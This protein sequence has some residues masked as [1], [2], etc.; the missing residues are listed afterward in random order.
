M[1]YQLTEARIH[2][3]A[4][5]KNINNLK[6]LLSSNTKFMA[7]VKADAYGHG[8]TNIAL[9]AL[10]SGAHWLGVARFEEALHI[11]HNKICAPLLVF[12]YVHPKH[13]STIYDRDIIST[14]YDY[15]MAKAL[16]KAAC[17]DNITIRAHLKIDT[18]MGRVGIVFGPDQV[19]SK[20]RKTIVRE[21]KKIL[22]LPGLKIEGIYTHLAASDNKDTTYTHLQLDAFD[23]LL[24]TLKKENIKFK[25]CHAANS[26]GILAFPRSHYDM[27]RAG[28]S[29]YGLY[30]SPEIDRSKAVL[31]PAMTLKSIIT[32]VRKVPKGFKVSYG[33]THETKE[34]TMLASVPVGYADGFSRLFSS[35]GVMLVKGQRAPVVGRVCM[36]Q[37]V[38]DIGHIPNVKPGDQVIL[39][40]EQGKESI[41]ADELANLAGTIN[42]EIV[43][44]LTARVE[45]IIF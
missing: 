3:D 40:G 6:S 41:T 26:G 44:S 4:I 10:E 15:D 36:D 22:G 23:T 7:V 8:A 29:M 35:N 1:E 39:M 43:S 12:G 20:L 34:K 5:K 2:L 28:I 32:S 21:I 13:V 25:M 24:L 18:G 45:K 31:F 11:R 9:K 27:V 42:Y 38:I 17:N 16:S 14:I 33:M 30:P 19:D 37:T